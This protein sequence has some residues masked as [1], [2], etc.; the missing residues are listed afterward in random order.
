MEPRYNRLNLRSCNL[1]V[2][3][4]SLSLIL[5]TQ[6]AGAVI[7]T[8]SEF[9]PAQWQSQSF[10]TQTST[11]SATT[12]ASGGNPAAHRSINLYSSTGFLQ[13][14]GRA[15]LVELKTSAVVSP[16]AVGGINLVDYS[17]DHRCTCLGGGVLWGPALEQGGTYYIVPGNATPNS[18]TLP[19]ETV[20]LSGLTAIDFAEV[21]VA[22]GTWS[23]PNSHPDFS[24]AGLPVTFG[25]VRAKAFVA[26]TNSV[27]DNWSVSVN[28][29][30]V[31]TEHQSWG[32]LK[33]LYR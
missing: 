27:L 8:D 33:S 22:S 24:A 21:D 6:P 2:L 13:P 12:A 4:V 5:I 11:A 30:V 26:H 16:A 10:L 32:T 20:T 23:N 18:F 15:M 7:F 9:V 25:F 1:I 19:W 29:T 17:E 14:V 31:D 28:E 3:A